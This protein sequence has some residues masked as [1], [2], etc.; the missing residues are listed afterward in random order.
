MEKSK[1]RE[2]IENPQK[3]EN[4]KGKWIKIDIE[5]WGKLKSG[6]KLRTN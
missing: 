4:W 5:N 1:I 6:Q 2:K 3:I